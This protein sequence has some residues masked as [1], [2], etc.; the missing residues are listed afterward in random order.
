MHIVK[1]GIYMFLFI[2]ICCM[3]PFFLLLF[4]GYFDRVEKNENINEAMCYILEV[5]IYRKTC[6]SYED[7]ISIGGCETIEYTCYD[8]D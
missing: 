2:G 3:M 8:E 1:S 6:I 5:N 7:W 4:L